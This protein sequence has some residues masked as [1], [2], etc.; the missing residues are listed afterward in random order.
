MI[1][2]PSG[3]A[4][5]QDGSDKPADNGLLSHRGYRHHLRTLTYGIRRTLVAGV[6]V[7][8]SWKTPRCPLLDSRQVDSACR[9]DK[10]LSQVRLQRPAPL[11]RPAACR[12]GL[13]PH[14]NR[15]YLM[16]SAISDSVL[17]T[18]SAACAIS[19]TASLM[20]SMSVW[21]PIDTR[22][23]SSAAVR[24]RPIASRT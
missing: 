8:P 23:D 16:P 4:R 3:R 11:K 13:A 19:D 9:C 6:S 22:T 15:Y 24:S 18:N 17:L 2:L 7:P 21:R 20:S 1:P 5:V 14:G 10:T 12:V